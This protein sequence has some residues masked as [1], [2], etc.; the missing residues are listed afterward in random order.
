M[1]EHVKYCKECEK[2]FFT[3]YSRQLYCNARCQ[4]KYNNRKA[5]KKRT[6]YKDKTEKWKKMQNKKRRE[7][8]YFIKKEL[9][10]LLGNKCIHCGFNDI[11]ALQ[12]DHINGGGVKELR[13]TGNRC[14]YYNRVLKSVQDGDNK[15]QLLCANCNWIK[16]HENNEK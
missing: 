12:I 16:R 1:T 3:N 6:P 13:S 11:R 8:I 14:V 2:L 5:A 9:F 7:K 4:F 15:Y 10:D